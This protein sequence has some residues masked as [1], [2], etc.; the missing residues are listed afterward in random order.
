MIFEIMVVDNVEKTR[1]DT[2]YRNKI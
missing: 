2:D 1:A